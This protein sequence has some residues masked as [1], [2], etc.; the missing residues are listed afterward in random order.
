L[1]IITREQQSV[2]VNDIIQNAVTLLNEMGE[3]PPSS[4]LNIDSP[5]V[6]PKL[7][8]GVKRL[9]ASIRPAEFGSLTFEDFEQNEKRLLNFIIRSRDPDGGRLITAQELAKSYKR[10]NFSLHGISLELNRGEIL[11]IVGVNASGKTTLLRMLLGEIKQA[12]G[13]LAFPSFC[14]DP[15]KPNWVHIKRRMG[16]VSQSLPRWPGRVFD[17]LRYIASIY[18]HKEADIDVYLDLL[19]QQYG[20]DK[21]KDAAWDEISGGY[22]TR[23]EIVRALLSR[24]DILFLDEPLAYLD[25]ISQQTVLRQLKQL[26]RNQ[27]YPIGVIVTSQ[28][29]Y[30]IESIADRLLVLD[31][32]HTLF[33]GPVTD[34]SNLIKHIV[35]EFAI[36]GFTKQIRKQISDHPHCMAILATETGYIG[37]FHRDD[38]HFSF[39]DVM[40]FLG[41]VSTG[42]LS[43]VR[44]VS[45]S[46]RLLF[47]P[48]MTEWLQTEKERQ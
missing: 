39:N 41:T 22:K 30:E 20:L 44:D 16:Y 15:L 13:L 18:G 42:R 33:S 12:K 32:G 40:G 3:S 17:N 45:N 19:L 25:I 31:G 1:R 14:D 36:T 6:D 43:Y 2:T 46:C 11:G 8:D 37:I 26:A 7:K 9:E 21:F 35:V 10:T 34:L 24:P 38:Q 47:E 23:F 27:E 5:G 29:L 48:R 4:R 28:Q